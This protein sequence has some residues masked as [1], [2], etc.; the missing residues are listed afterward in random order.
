MLKMRMLCNLGTSSSGQTNKGSLKRHHIE[1]ECEG[2]S[3]TDEETLMLL[4]G[5]S[6]CPDCERPLGGRS[7]LPGSSDDQESVTDGGHHDA[8]MLLDYSTPEPTGLESPF[9]HVGTSTKLQAVV[10]NIAASELV[11]KSIVFSFWT[12]T[13]DHLAKLIRHA[14][15]TYRQ[16]DGRTSPA[17]RSRALKAFKEDAEVHVLLM[18]IGTGALGLNLTVASRVHLV[19]PQWNPFVEDQAIARALRMG[20]TREVTILRYM[21]KDT[22]EENI[23]NLQKRKKA[24]SKFTFDTGMGNTT[25]DTIEDIRTVFEMAPN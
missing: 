5:R 7:P 19:E 10:R 2:C 15:I 25:S 12:S 24:L 22:V 21:I 20:Q 6:T 3:A 23:V 16:I 9:F 4:E 18:S 13:L 1:V 8:D 11:E 14:N 17:D